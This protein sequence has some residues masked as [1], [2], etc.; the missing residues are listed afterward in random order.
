MFDWLKN[1]FRKEETIEE[2]IYRPT[3]YISLNNSFEDFVDTSSYPTSASN[4][5]K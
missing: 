5:Y 4:Y 3:E 2:P 1:L